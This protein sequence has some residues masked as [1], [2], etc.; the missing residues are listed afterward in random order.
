MP[1]TT[2]RS[3]LRDIRQTAAATIPPLGVLLLSGNGGGMTR[4]NGGGVLPGNGGG[5]VGDVF[6]GLLSNISG[7]LEVYRRLVNGQSDAQRMTGV[8]L[9]DN[10]AARSRYA[11]EA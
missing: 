6:M 8:T 5:G 2:D 9:D 3:T 1:F 7:I 4:G 11:R 10:G